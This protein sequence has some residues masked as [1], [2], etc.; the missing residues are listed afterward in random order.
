M[1]VEELDSGKSIEQLLARLE[2][3]ELIRR[4]VELGNG[5][6][7]LSQ[8][9]GGVEFRVSDIEVVKTFG[10]A[11]QLL[12]IGN[13]Q[14]AGHLADM[15]CQLDYRVTICDPREDYQSAAQLDGVQY[16]REM[17][18]DAV[19]DLSDQA[20]TAIVALA[21][22]PRQDDLGL[23]AALD[24]R[25]FYIG[26]MGSRTSAQVRRGRLEALGYKPDQIER[27]HGPAGLTIGSKRPAEIAVSILAQITAV[28]NGIQGYANQVNAHE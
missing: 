5:S 20:R 9:D 24:S 27:I 6:T 17:P 14:L 8:G 4:R 11:W 26:A 3:G 28:R 7:D 10:P 1:P 2:R 19:R 21:H 18:D 15:A 13:G 25:A 16:I 12:I 23:S 22:D